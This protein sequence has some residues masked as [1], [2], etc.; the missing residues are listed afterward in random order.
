MALCLYYYLCY[1]LLPLLFHFT[2]KDCIIFPPFI[3]IRVGT[4]WNSCM[5]NTSLTSTCLRKASGHAFMPIRLLTYNGR[6]W[7]RC[8]GIFPRAADVQTPF[9]DIINC[10]FRIDQSTAPWQRSTR[11]PNLATELRFAS[12][13]EADGNFERPFRL[14]RDPCR[15]PACPYWL[16]GDPPL[17]SCLG[18]FVSAGFFRVD[19]LKSQ[20]RAIEA[21][22]CPYPPVY[23]KGGEH[24]RERKGAH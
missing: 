9:G 13:Q 11:I 8:P 21:G 4:L 15:I 22:S 7:S 23:W 10:L 2:C 3:E 17:S 1:L 5:P 12:A 24:I 6:R 20:R 18:V 16:L 19:L 14:L